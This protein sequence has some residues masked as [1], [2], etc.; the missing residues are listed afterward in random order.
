M[1]ERSFEDLLKL[2]VKPN[3]TVCKGFG[4]IQGDSATIEDCPSCYKKKQESKH[5]SLLDKQM[6]KLKRIKNRRSK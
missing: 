4:F 6:H 1:N 5:I 3:C 2:K